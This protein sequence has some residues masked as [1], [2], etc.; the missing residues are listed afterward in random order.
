MGGAFFT[1]NNSHPAVVGKADKGRMRTISAGMTLGH[2]RQHKHF[3]R[4]HPGAYVPV[5]DPLGG[6]T[7]GLLSERGHSK[8][9][10]HP[11][12]ELRWGVGGW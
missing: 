10:L 12:Q 4:L 7:A 8:A 3:C 6:A 9:I 2:V 1:T 11:L 5:A